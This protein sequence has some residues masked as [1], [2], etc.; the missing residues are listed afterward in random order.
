MGGGAAEAGGRGAL[1]FEGPCAA[2]GADESAEDDVDV[3]DGA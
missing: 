1:L 2:G 3:W